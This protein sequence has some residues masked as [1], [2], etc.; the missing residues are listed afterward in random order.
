MKR[1]PS[2]L[3]PWFEARRRFKLSRAQIQMA[4]ELGMNPQKFGALANERQEPW[5]LPLPEF[6]AECYCKR[7]GRSEPETVRSL[8]EVV[9]AQDRRRQEKQARKAEKMPAQVNALQRSATKSDSS[10]SSEDAPSQHMQWTR[11]EPRAVNAPPFRRH[12]CSAQQS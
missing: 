6:I 8:E 7:F 11:N 5:K 9:Q 2:K 10:P 4:R 12:D 1:M 3:Q